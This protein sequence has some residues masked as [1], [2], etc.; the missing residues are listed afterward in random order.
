M[1]RATHLSREFVSR[2]QKVAALRGLTMHIKEGEG[3]APL[4]AS[5]SGKSTLLNLL[6]ALDEPT[7]G[8]VVVAG[9][10]L[11]QLSRP[12]KAR[13]RRETVGMVFQSFQLIPQRTALENT[14]LPLVLAWLPAARRRARAAECL[15]R[16]GLSSRSSHLPCELSGGEQQRVAVARALANRPRVLLAD[17]PTGNLDTSTAAGV[18]KLISEICDDTQMTLVVVTHDES[19]A[20]C[21]AGRTLRM[22]EGTLLPEVTR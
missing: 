8:S 6:A 2:T 18:V 4:G 9:Q 16:V 22:S 17:E 5:G 14:E 7:G 11:N 1:I 15:D 12:K 13:F 3:V 19:L 20:S 21:V 10:P